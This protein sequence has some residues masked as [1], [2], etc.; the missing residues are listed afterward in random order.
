[1]RCA[2]SERAYAI[3]TAHFFVRAVRTKKRVSSRT[4]LYYCQ[5]TRGRILTGFSRPSIFASSYIARRST[6]V[7]RSKLHFSSRSA[8]TSLAR[9]SSTSSCSSRGPSR[10]HRASS[11]C[12]MSVR[13]T[14]CVEC[15]VD[16]LTECLMC[17]R[18]SVWSEVVAL[19]VRFWSVRSYFFA[20]P[21][22]RNRS[23]ERWLTTYE[24]TN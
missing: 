21:L 5:R 24:E 22:D 20:L 6:T 23:A 7:E 11:P 9:S 18:I 12:W 14:P 8:N 10:C 17:R 16:T 2:P 13:S 15:R 3:C 4:G 19:A 1:M